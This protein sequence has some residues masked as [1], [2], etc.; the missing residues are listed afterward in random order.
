V[1]LWP[2]CLVYISIGKYAVWWSNK[3]MSWIGVV[4]V[5]NPWRRVSYGAAP[6]LYT[7]LRRSLV[8]KCV[9]SS[10][11]QDVY[12][13]VYVQWCNEIWDRSSIYVP[14]ASTLALVNDSCD[15]HIRMIL[16]TTN[17]H[18]GVCYYAHQCTH[19]CA[20]STCNYTF[21]W[22]MI[23]LTIIMP[24][25]HSGKNAAYSKKYIYLI[26]QLAT[27]FGRGVPPR[28]LLLVR[29]FVCIE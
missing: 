18:S 10:W 4:A 3:N 5:W 12:H 2:E 13:F 1:P 24:K 23:S 20:T 17:R 11:I 15:N 29:L 6:E 26:L 7:H 25:N 27:T 28:H 14:H 16:K 9:L 8:T 19:T 21:A 22:Y